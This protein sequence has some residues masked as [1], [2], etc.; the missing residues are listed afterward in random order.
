MASAEHGTRLRV[1][2]VA[3]AVGFL[4]TQCIRGNVEDECLKL[5]QV[6][7]LQG[8]DDEAVVH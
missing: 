6:A 7:T 3:G 1:I 8:S 2:L 4:Q 5:I